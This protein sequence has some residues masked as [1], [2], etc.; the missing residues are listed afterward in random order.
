MNYPQQDRL[1]ATHCRT[2]ERMVCR[3]LRLHLQERMV[4]PNS[5]TDYSLMNQPLYCQNDDG[6]KF[7]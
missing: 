3:L 7:S 1:R 6:L 4:F 5:G 2:P